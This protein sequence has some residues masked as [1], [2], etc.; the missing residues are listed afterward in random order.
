MA[1][2]PALLLLLLLHELEEELESLESLLLLLLDLFLAIGDLDL[3][4]T[5]F[6]SSKKNN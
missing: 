4:L 1:Y 5:F 3:S 6:L 2:S